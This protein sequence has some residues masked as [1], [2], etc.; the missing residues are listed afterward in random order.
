M[1]RYDRRLK[2]TESSASGPRPGNSSC[3]LPSSSVP[4]RGMLGGMLYS[5]NTQPQVG[6]PGDVRPNKING[7]A[8]LKKHDDKIARLEQ[9]LEELEKNYVENLSRME[10]RLSEREKL[11]NLRNGE[12]KTEMKKMKDYI[13]TLKKKMKALDSIEVEET[14]VANST[15]DTETESN[16]DENKTSVSVDS[17]NVILK[18]IENENEE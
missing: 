7:V 6:R 18:V 12:F 8:V 14:A 10:V 5:R 16:N 15:L 3:S 4:S 17:E 11:F 9:R 13:I 1:S 2:G